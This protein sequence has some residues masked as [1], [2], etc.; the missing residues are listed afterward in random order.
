MIRCKGD[1]R[2]IKKEMLVLI[3]YLMSMGEKNNLRK[4]RLLSFELH[5]LSLCRLICLGS[6]QGYIK[7][8]VVWIF[9]LI[10]W[11]FLV[12]FLI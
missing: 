5:H 9:L 4:C 8:D 11:L 2:E 3:V 6:S 12:L 1:E 7:F 10:F